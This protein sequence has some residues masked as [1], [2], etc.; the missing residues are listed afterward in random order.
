[1]PHSL[2]PWVQR[3]HPGWRVAKTHTQRAHT[4]KKARSRRPPPLEG[5]RQRNA[6]H[7]AERSRYARSDDTVR[8]GGARKMSAVREA[9]HKRE[10]QPPPQTKVKKSHLGGQMVHFRLILGCS[11]CVFHRRWGGAPDFAHRAH[12]SNA[13]EG[14]EARYFNVYTRELFSQFVDVQVQASQIYPT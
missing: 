7:S 12:F 1:M 4:H 2:S 3:W 14:I 11:G 13:L 8:S 10:R 5:S 6:N 9:F